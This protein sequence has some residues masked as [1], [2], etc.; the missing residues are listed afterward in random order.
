MG[1]MECNRNGCDNITCEHYSREYGYI[2]DDCFEELVN[3]GPYYDIE[4][5]MNT[6][7]RK[8]KEAEARARF[9]A[10]FRKT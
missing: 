6:P 2:C 3:C 5:F 10:V 4:I 8:S 7:K 1:V 9:T